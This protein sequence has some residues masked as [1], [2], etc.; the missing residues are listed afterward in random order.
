MDGPAV[1][2]LLTQEEPPRTRQSCPEQPTDQRGDQDAVH[3]LAFE[4][5]RA[6]RSGI[7]MDRVVVAMSLLRD[8]WA[9]SRWATDG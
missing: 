6:R 9:A 3:D 7:E 2:Q 5:G 8:D 4:P 1:A